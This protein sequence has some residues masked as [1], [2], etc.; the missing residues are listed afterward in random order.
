MYSHFS[1][2]MYNT[3]KHKN[4]YCTKRA[5]QWVFFP[6]KKT[7]SFFVRLLYRTRL[8]HTRRSSMRLRALYA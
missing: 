5:P 8:C 6:K 2:Y 1:Y 7:N 3:L 4:T